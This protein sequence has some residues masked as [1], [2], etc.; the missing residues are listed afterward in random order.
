MTLEDIAAVQRL[1]DEQIAAWSR[2]DADGYAS[3]AEEDLSFTNILGQRFVGRRAFVDIHRQRFETIFRGSQLHGTTERIDVV[4]AD[5]VLVEVLLHLSAIASA[6]PGIALE[7][8]GTLRTRLVQLFARRDH[9]WTLVCCHNVAVST[10]PAMA[11]RA[12][13]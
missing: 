5:V 11:R 1:V 2:G 13:G 9:G 10:A 6:P 7:H 8:D 12:L 3:T 4:G